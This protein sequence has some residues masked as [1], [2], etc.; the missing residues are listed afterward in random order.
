MKLVRLLF[1]RYRVWRHYAHYLRLCLRAERAYARFET[2]RL[3]TQ[4]PSEIACIRFDAHCADQAANDALL[5]LDALK[6][7]G[8]EP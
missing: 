1:W 6:A 3:Y 5:A 4:N 7:W 2:A 8:P